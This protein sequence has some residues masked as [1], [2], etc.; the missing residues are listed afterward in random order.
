MIQYISTTD[1]NAFAGI[2]LQHGPSNISRIGFSNG[3]GARGPLEFSSAWNGQ[4]PIVVRQY[5][6]QNVFNN[7]RNE[8]TLL[9]ANGNTR[10]PRNLSFHSVPSTI[11]WVSGT[12][13]SMRFLN[14]NS[15][16]WMEWA[17]CG[18]MTKSMHVRQYQGQGWTTIDRTLTLSDGWGN[19]SIPRNLT[20]GGTINGINLA[21][22]QNELNNHTH[23]DLALAN[24]THTNFALTNHSHNTFN[25]DINLNAVA[26]SGTIARN[27][28]WNI[29]N[30]ELARIGIQ[31][32]RLEISSRDQFRRLPIAFNQRI[33]DEVAS[34]LSLLDS[35]GNT[36]IPN[37][38]NVGGTI[39]AEK[40]SQQL[41]DMI[42]PIG[43][44]QTFN[45]IENRDNFV[46]MMH[47]RYGVKWSAGLHDNTAVREK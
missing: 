17:T 26:I 1:N 42:H 10:I 4:M 19:T 23:E 45:T 8:L 25:N 20:V 3:N 44:I 33:G 40:F 9:D 22:M 2:H 18:N 16:D 15:V 5:T 30:S 43:S 6:G 47:E 32:N 39:H 14:N 31:Q 21:N 24:H 35:N 28:I 29:N 37:N 46:N 12:I 11:E 34:T 38:L 41:I 13:P 27:L 7:I 36:S